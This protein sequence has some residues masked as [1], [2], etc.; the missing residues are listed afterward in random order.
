MSLSNSTLNA[1]QKVGAAVFTAD[2]KL[3]KEVS[4]YAERVNAAITKNPYNLEN[5]TLIEGWKVVARLS[6]TLTGIEE[7]LRNVYQVASKLAADDQPVV[8]DMPALP[9]P[10]QFASRTKRGNEGATDVVVK[11]K[12][13]A[14]ATK[15]KASKVK[16]ASDS[17]KALKPGSNPAK[18]L[19]YFQR[20]LTPNEFS[21]VRQTTAAQETGIPL[22]SMSAAIKK[23]I[24]T[25]FI[26]AGS[27]G[28]VMMKSELVNPQGALNS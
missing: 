7:E 18:L 3:K 22:G 25:G 23:L 16:T 26:T 17:D 10:T 12:K 8:S 20:T 24:E 1:I 5:D 6:R 14:K 4:D 21:E 28:R 13:K 27:D 9:G 11:A 2:A 15:V 19:S